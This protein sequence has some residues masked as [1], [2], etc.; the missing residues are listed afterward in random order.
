MAPR[1]DLVR[2][3][4]VTRRRRGSAVVAALLLLSLLSGVV[5]ASLVASNDS[6]TT[7]P[8]RTG[9]DA[10]PAFAFLQG[11]SAGPFRWDP[12]APIHYEW[13]IA[14]APD[15]VLE[16]LHEV[17]RRI[18]EDTGIEFIDDGSTDRT[19]RQ[20][21]ADRFVQPD[22][23]GQVPLPVLVTWVPPETFRRYA[24]PRRYA[25]VGMAVPLGSDYG[26]YRSGLVV[27]NADR[28]LHLGFE[29]R[30]SHGVILQHEW[31][32]VL[33]LAH[34]GSPNELMW[35]SDVEGA[36]QIPDLSLADWGPGDLRGLEKLGR[37]AGC[38]SP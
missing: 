16:D 37:D 6:R 8:G 27:M 34:V 7:A 18:G 20:Q 15:G 3:P 5:G 21:R 24:N 22:V 28:F 29:G 38:M 32:H 4:P 2:A 30:F 1:P 13:N 17:I 33:G 35:S 31:G 19:D 10:P 14:Q 12:C 26:V 9:A 11:T 36:A 23:A 25:G